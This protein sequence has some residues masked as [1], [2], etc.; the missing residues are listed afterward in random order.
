MI[1]DVLG[2]V[3]LVLVMTVNPGAGGQ[4]LISSTLPKIRQVR[5]MINASERDIHLGVDGGINP[6]TVPLV[7]EVGANV[8]VVG[9]AVFS[10]NFTVQQ[11]IDR[12]RQ[13]VNQST[14]T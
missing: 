13:A 8:L 3:D 14:K 1:S 4:E 2:L 9:S 6:E 7:V 5:E 10:A 12:L 11:G